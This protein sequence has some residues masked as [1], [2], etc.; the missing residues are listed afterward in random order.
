MRAFIISDGKADKTEGRVNFEG[1]IEHRPIE[2]NFP[3]ASTF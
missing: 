3:T 2:F 1:S